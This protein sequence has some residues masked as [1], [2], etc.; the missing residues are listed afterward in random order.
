MAARDALIVH[1]RA[2]L[3]PVGAGGVEAQQRRALA[4]LLDID[5]MLAPEQIEMHVT[6]DD[7]LELRGH[8]TALAGRSLANASLK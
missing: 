1:Q 6:A 8:A 4:C 7:R 5:A 2:V 3:A